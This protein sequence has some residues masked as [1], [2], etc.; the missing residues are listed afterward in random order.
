MTSVVSRAQTAKGGPIP[1]TNSLSSGPLV[2]AKGAS[3]NSTLSGSGPVLGL[4]QGGGDHLQHHNHNQHYPSA[5]STSASAASPQADS[6]GGSIPSGIPILQTAGGQGSTNNTNNGAGN[7]SNDSVLDTHRRN[8]SSSKLPAYRFADLKNGNGNTNKNGGG[9]GGG[10]INVST[11]NPN[12]SSPRSSIIPNLSKIPGTRV[13]GSSSPTKINSWVATT[14]TSNNREKRESKIPT[15]HSIGLPAAVLQKHIPPSPV[16]PKPGYSHGDDQ[17]LGFELGLEELQHQ[18]DEG[19]APDTPGPSSSAA[20]AAPA[21]AAPATNSVAAATTTTTIPSAPTSASGTN[22]SSSTITASAFAHPNLDA[23]SHSGQNNPASASAGKL[24]APGPSVTTSSFARSRASTFQSASTAAVT[25]SQ[26]SNADSSSTLPD[27]SA[28]RPVSYPQSPSAAKTYF[29]SPTTSALAQS[30]VRPTLSTSPTGQS[31]DQSLPPVGVDTISRGGPENSTRHHVRGHQKELVLSTTIDHGTHNFHQAATVACSPIDSTTTPSAR[32]SN[33]DDKRTSRRPPVSFKPPLSTP[34]SAS[35]AS[36]RAVIPPIRAFRSS[37]SRRSLVLDMNTRNSR[38][39]D[40]GDDPADSN[41]RDRTLRA[42]EGRDPDDPSHQHYQQSTNLDSSTRD[43]G[44]GHDDGGDMFLRI[45]REEFARKSSEE[46]REGSTVSRVTRAS[47]SRRPYSA[48]VPT[49]QPTSPPRISRRLSDQQETK[50]SRAYDDDRTIDTI[51]RPSGYR[52]TMDRL[53]SASEQSRS[54]SF[55]PAAPLKSNPITPRASTFQDSASDGPSAYQKRRGSITDSNVNVPRPPYKNSSLS[56]SRTYNSSPLAPKH[57]T[58]DVSHGFESTEST[59]STNA[60]SVMWD[61]VDKMKSQIERIQKKGTLPANSAISR[62]SDERPPTATTTVTT[63]STSPKRTS[64]NAAQAAEASSTTS[65]YKE[66]HPILQAAL[67]RTK[68]AATPEVYRALEAAANDAMV[69]AS[70]MGSAGQPGPISSG[71]SS[72][73]NGITVTDRQL[74]RKADSVCRSLTELCIALS[75]GNSRKSPPIIQTIEP[76]IEQETITSPTAANFLSA[77]PMRRP[78]A[79][80]TTMN[81][82]PR[83]ISRLEERRNNMMNCGAIPSPRLLP[84]SSGDTPSAGRKSSLLISRTRRAGTEEPDDGRRS[85]LLRSRRA[86]TE[87]PD[88]GRKSSLFVRSRRNTIGDS[89][90]ESRH[91]APSRANTTDLAAIRALNR[92]REAIG[93][94][95]LGADSHNLGASALPRRRLPPSA[96]GGSSR[97]AAPASTPTTSRRYIDRSTPDRD[98]VIAADRFGEE[99]SQRQYNR[100]IGLLGRSG[101]LSRRHRDSTISGLSATPS[102]SNY[103]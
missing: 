96:L 68:P 44:H 65:S 72:I 7:N 11:N 60:P 16:S 101:S 75:D 33:S 102:S 47:H 4:G 87:E 70:M 64:G 88:D 83:N 21:P 82:S 52:E 20:P 81:S 34:G 73:G 86:G 27:S 94:Q 28:G 17:G 76:S 56:Y 42:L 32:R 37:G 8:H 19:P 18:L 26:G 30:G 22:T 5:V 58:S 99:R 46:G 78:S 69:L 50:R 85:S 9:G 63:M 54:R 57:E 12:N 77:P 62:G 23:P 3:H 103:R 29:R 55:A 10:I 74:R 13:R 31:A 41:H 38:P 95:V 93:N 35:Q 1:L 43:R 59:A 90:D 36:G 24:F 89:D 48:A 39:Y 25:T 51:T 2:P 6:S 80:E 91:R 97:L 79:V 49:Y 14:A 15:T 66:P 67:S 40:F 100:P 92:E 98:S 53:A 61:E 45:A 84:N 71:A